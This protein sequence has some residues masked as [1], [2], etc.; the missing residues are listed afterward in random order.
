MGQVLA[1]LTVLLTAG[2]V[3]GPAW[4]LPVN[5]HPDSVRLTRIGEFGLLR[6]AR[7]GIPAHLHAGIDIARP[8]DNYHHEPVYPV[9]PG[10]V[11]SLRDDGPFAQLI[12]EHRLEN[13][14][15][16]WSVYEHVSGMVC[17]LGDTVS[18]EH[19]LARFMN[20]QEL[21]RHGWQFDHLHLE[22]MRIPP[23]PRSPDPRLPYCRYA[24][25]GLTCYV[26]QEL[27][28]R[29]LDPIEFLGAKTLNI[30]FSGKR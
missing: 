15:K 7:P 27:E 13:G 2:A 17:S 28:A 21:D 8:S 26:R 30:P 18:P 10:V 20:R 19:P 6:R 1:V 29:Y 11:V 24:T 16:L 9:G 4:R 23:R 25:Y 3:G 14:A 5:C 22:I 12:I